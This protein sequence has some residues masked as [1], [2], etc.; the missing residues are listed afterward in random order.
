MDKFIGEDVKV[1]QAEDSPRPVRFWWHGQ[2]HQ[3]VQILDERLDIGF[4]EIPRGSRKWFNRRHRRYYLVKDQDGDVFEMYQ[5]YSNRQRVVWHL[6]KRY[7][8]R[9]G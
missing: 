2:E 8:L 1:E 6:L 9:A 4:G 5:D 7:R 3:I